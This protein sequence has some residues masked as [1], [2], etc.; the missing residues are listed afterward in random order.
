MKIDCKIVE[1]LLPLYLDN[2]C[3]EQTKAAVEDHLRQC[4][5]CQKL[6]D[7]TQAVELPHI[8]LEPSKGELAVK[9]GFRK[10]RIRWWASILATVILL[11]L[12]L[13]SWNQYHNRGVHYS[14]IHELRIGNAFMQCIDEGNYKKAYT[15]IDIAGLEQEWLDRWFDKKTLENIEADGLKKF[16]EYGEALEAHGGIAGYKYIGISYCGK[17]DDGTDI[18]QLAFK[19]KYAGEEAPFSIMVSND[20]IEY[21]SGNGSFVTDPLAQFA[22]WSEYLW[23]SYE[24]CYYDPDLQEYVYP[25]E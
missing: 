12:L 22:I 6:I 13:L 10:I 11:P 14:N 25:D 19:I 4:P 3:S 17:E 1:D 20:G 7:H 5:E 18:Y 24:G 23:Q 2:V 16:C 8:T 15:Y 21:F 9:K